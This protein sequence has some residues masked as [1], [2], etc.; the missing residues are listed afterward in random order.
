MNAHDL[1]IV[2]AAAREHWNSMF[3]QPGVYSADTRHRLYEAV[4][5]AE[6]ELLRTPVAISD[7][8]V[9]GSKVTA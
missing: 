1:A 4:F 6:G 9:I 8:D 3:K 7:E 5:H 2:T